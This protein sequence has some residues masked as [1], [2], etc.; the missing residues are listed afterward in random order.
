MTDFDLVKKVV[1]R[2]VGFRAK[3]ERNSQDLVLKDCDQEVNGLLTRSLTAPQI[4]R[5]GF[6]FRCLLGRSVVGSFKD[7]SVFSEK[8][9]FEKIFLETE[10]ELKKET[11]GK[12]FIYF[13]VV[14]RFWLSCFVASQ[15]FY[16][17]LIAPMKDKEWISFDDFKK[18]IENIHQ[19]NI[20]RA[21]LSDKEDKKY[22]FNLRIQKMLCNE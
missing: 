1:L 19:R 4:D 17:L 2:F 18:C 13:S 14:I 8:L 21:F 12:Q 20:A 22:S 5:E 9:V 6:I 11:N 15:M 7:A 3:I 10:E 16:M